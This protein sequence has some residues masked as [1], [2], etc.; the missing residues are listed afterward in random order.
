MSMV[1]EEFETVHATG[2]QTWKKQ[3]RLLKMVHYGSYARGDCVDDTVGGY[4]SDFG[5]FIVASDERLAD[6]ARHK[7]DIT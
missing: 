3:G 6:R 5:I 4:K 2:T 1:F 7:R